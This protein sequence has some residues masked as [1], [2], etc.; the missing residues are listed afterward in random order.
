M[1]D[2]AIKQLLIGLQKHINERNCYPVAQLGVRQILNLKVVGSSPTG[3]AKYNVVKT[4]ENN[5]RYSILLVTALLAGCGEGYLAKF[6]CLEYTP[7][8]ISGATP[9]AI[10]SCIKGEYFCVSPLVMTQNTS[11]TPVCIMPND[12]R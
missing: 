10:V 4:K 12:K 9:N 1:E 5:M 3:V 6:K 2:G 8:P 11:G 7:A